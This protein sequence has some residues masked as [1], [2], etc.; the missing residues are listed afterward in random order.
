MVM[1]D[2][3]VSAVFVSEK[4]NPTNI[5]FLGD[6]FFPKKDMV[7]GGRFEQIVKAR[8]D[9]LFSKEPFKEYKEYFSVY[10]VSSFSSYPDNIF[11]SEY[12]SIPGVHRSLAVGDRNLAREYAAKAIPNL[13]IIV[14]ILDSFA[15]GGTGGNGIA[16]SSL[17]SYY[18][19]VHEIGHVFGLADEYI[20]DD[21]A[22]HRNL[23]NPETIFDQTKNRPNVDTTNDPTKVKW[24]HFIG[25]PG[26][27][28]EGV[29][30]GGY[31][32]SKGVWRPTSDSIMRSYSASSP[33]FNA[34]SRETIVKGILA[35][36]GETYDFNEFL[37]RD[38][39]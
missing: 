22:E 29:Y 27:E 14:V 17:A 15:P 16:T 3:F 38:K 4:A 35:N 33:K 8:V 30:E 5:V 10:W 11:K 32:V 9:H 19:V 25:R 12:E 26:Y 18:T 21:L 1:D 20:D 39:P 34:I 28:S 6:G 13:Q 7:I 24:A 23:T 2:G 37:R 36:A 31:Y